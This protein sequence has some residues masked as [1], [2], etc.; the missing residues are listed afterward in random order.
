[1]DIS[2]TRT[3]N[4]FRSALALYV[5]Q[6]GISY[7]RAAEELG[8]NVWH[9]SNFLNDPDW[10]PSRRVCRLLNIRK[11]KPCKRVVIYA[12]SDMEEKSDEIN[13]LTNGKWR[14][15]RDED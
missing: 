3:P 15:V 1:M 11:R 8:V 14:I 13:E 4:E 2:I 10:T 9:I 6:G 5:G 7:E 12:G